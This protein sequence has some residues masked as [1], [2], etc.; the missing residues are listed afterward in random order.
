MSPV[1]KEKESKKV[2][3]E[4]INSMEDRMRQLANCL[5]D[6]ILEDY[7]NGTLLFPNVSNSDKTNCKGIEYG[8]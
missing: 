8:P 1:I 5:I 2:N 6:R 3:H 4:P 7:E